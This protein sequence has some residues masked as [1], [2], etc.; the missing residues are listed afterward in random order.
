M[1]EFNH[2]EVANIFKEIDVLV[3]PSIWQE[4][5]PLV[6]QEAFL[7]KTPVIA[8][9]IGGIPELIK[10]KENGLLFEPGN[11]DDLY[12]KMN[13]LIN[14]PHLIK[15]LKDGIIPPKSIQENALEIEE[16]YMKGN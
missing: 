8:S 15:R 4:N 7:S 6:I 9:R 3:A 11:P 5:S 14:D 13:I 12:D 16:L 2:Q 1:G 10:D